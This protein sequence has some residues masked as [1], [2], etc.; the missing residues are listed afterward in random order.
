MQTTFNQ[1]DFYQTPQ[2]TP[3]YN[4]GF[5][6]D[7][8]DGFIEILTPGLDKEDIKVS[9]SDN[10]LTVKGSYKTNPKEYTEQNIELYDFSRKFRLQNQNIKSVKLKNG[11][12]RINLKEIKP[13]VVRIEID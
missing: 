13:E 5:Q 6:T 3:Y 7:T 8:Q 10:Y 2:E 4:I 12:L 11:I 1:E 9:V